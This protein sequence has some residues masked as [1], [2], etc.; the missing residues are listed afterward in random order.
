[1]KR[2]KSLSILIPCYNEEDNIRECIKRIPSMRWK[3]EVLV[4]DDGSSDKTTQFAKGV[5]YRGR[6]KTIHY[7]PNRGKGHAVRKGLE[8]ARGDVAIILDADMSSPP[9]E[10]PLIVKPIFEGKADF[11]NGTRLVYPM[12]KGAMKLIHIPGNRIF[13]LLVSMIVGKYL[14]DSLC[15]FKAFKVKP[16]ARKLKEDSWPDFELLIKAKRMGM[17]IVEVPIHYKVRVGGVSKM[18]TIRHGYNMLNMLL[19][20]LKKDY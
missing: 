8:A 16:F 4:I 17:K 10:I 2:P 6:L 9:E 14:T 5:G 19:R 3:T 20:S 7:K 18:K 12:D 1:M 13:A 15:G 11:V